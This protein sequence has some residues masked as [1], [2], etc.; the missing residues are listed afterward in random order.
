MS[1][2]FPAPTLSII[3]TTIR[4][5][6]ESSACAT[7]Q[8][9]TSLISFIRISLLNV[10][11]GKRHGSGVYRFKSGARYE[12]QYADGRKEGHGV[13]VNPDGSRYE[14]EWS[15]DVRNGK[16]VYFYPNGDRYEGEWANNKRHGYGVYHY[17]A[18]GSVF[19][20]RW[21]E[22]VW[23]GAGELLHT[24]HRFVGSFK[25][26]LPKGKGRYVFDIGCQQV[27]EY[28]HQEVVDP[29][30]VQDD[31]PES[32]EDNTIKIPVWT[33]SKLEPIS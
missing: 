16:G 6:K 24:R 3:S 32:E 1:V 2:D 29:N 26:G 12:G 31:L 17:K 27:G 8:A 23:H 10:S 4:H 5:G 22:G 15:G 14:G 13:F 9:I 21:H 11:L 25:D 18:T 30:I 19:Q 7:I 20:G 28:I 33:A